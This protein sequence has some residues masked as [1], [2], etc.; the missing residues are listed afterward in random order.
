MKK[1]KITPATM[2]A[3]VIVVMLLIVVVIEKGGLL[4]KGID[5][6]IFYAAIIIGIVALYYALRKNE[7]IKAGQPEN[8]EMSMM[9]KYKAGY[10]AYMASMYMWLFIFLFRD[11]FPSPETMVGGGILMSALIFFITKYTVKNEM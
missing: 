9:I 8:D 3:A 1:T 4:Q 10:K 7:E 5:I 2:I 6:F 11:K